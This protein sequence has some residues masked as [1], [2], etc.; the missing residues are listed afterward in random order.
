MNQKEKEQRQADIQSRI[1]ILA[2]ELAPL[3]RKTELLQDRIA[4]LEIDLSIVRDAKVE[5]VKEIR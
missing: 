4:N 3:L 1:K 2:A 5:R